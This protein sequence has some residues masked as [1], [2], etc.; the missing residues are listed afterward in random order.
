VP[1]LAFLGFFLMAA[2]WSVAMPYEGAPDE[3]DHVVRAAGVVAGQVAPKPAAV[4]AGSGAIQTV[5]RGLIRS[6]ANCW[7][8]KPAVPVGCAS[9]PGSDRTLA[10]APTGAGRYPPLYYA[11]VGAPLRLWPGM[12][13][14]ILARLIG[15][16]LCAGL[17]AAAFAAVWR[18]SRHR[19]MA[20]GLLLAFTPIAAQLCGSVNPNG[21]E[22]VSG[23]ALFAAGLPLFAGYR[24]R[25]GEPRP[26][27]DRRLLALF[28]VSAI[29]LVTMRTSGPPWLLVA[30]AM[31][32]A[33]YRPRL[34]LALWRDRAARAWFAGLAVALLAGVVWTLVMKATDFGDYRLTQH[35]SPAQVAWQIADRWRGWLD[36][37][38]GVLGF[39]DTRLPGWA[40]L[41]WESLA[42]GVLLWALVAVRGADRWRLAAAGALAILVPSAM[43]FIGANTTGFITQG[44]YV[45][46]LLVGVVLMAVDV[47]DRRVLTGI[48]ARG[49]IRLCVVVLLPIQL[50]GLL[51]GMM[52][53]QQGIPAFPGLAQF[54]PSHGSWHPVLGSWLPVL[55]EVA[56]LLVVAALVLRA[57]RP[58]GADGSAAGPDRGTESE[59]TERA[60]SLAESTEETAAQPAR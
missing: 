15:A 52:R 22:I 51:I 19:L 12:P 49:L 60:G 44:R 38:V 55:A 28:G 42:G 27:W 53:Y 1:L 5:P 14:L 59:P 13:G 58:V 54:N 40:Y 3:I 21:I 35:L 6:N 8:H 16:A 25:P 47:L 43:Q 36:E 17:I 32:L 4:K 30:L 23:I 56:G 39:M 50:V 46:P 7:I 26:E 20:A 2:A 11:A 57:P 18:W 31:L 24:W 29:V 48:Q 33:P 37:A 10:H 34:F 9:P 41:I 45:L